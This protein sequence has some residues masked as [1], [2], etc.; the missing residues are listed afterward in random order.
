MG[1]K[2]PTTLKKR[3]KEEDVQPMGEEQPKKRGRP[4][5]GNPE[6]NAGTEGEMTLKLTEAE[7]RF[8]SSRVKGRKTME[9][10]LLKYERMSEVKGKIIEFTTD[11]DRWRVVEDGGESEGGSGYWL[12]E[13]EEDERGEY[14]DESDPEYDIFDDGTPSEMAWQDSGLDEEASRAFWLDTP[15]IPDSEFKSHPFPVF[16]SLGFGISPTPLGATGSPWSTQRGAHMSSLLSVIALYFEPTQV[17][18]HELLQ[19]VWKSFAAMFGTNMTQGHFPNTLNFPSSLPAVSTSLLPMPQ[20][21]LVRSGTDIGQ[22][23]F[24]Y[25]QASPPLPHAVPSALVSTPPRTIVSS[26]LRGFPSSPLAAHSS[27]I[28]TQNQLV[29]S[30]RR[31]WSTLPRMTTPLKYRFVSSA[32]GSPNVWNRSD[33]YTGSSPR[34]VPSSSTFVTFKDSRRLSQR[35]RRPGRGL[36]CLKKIEEGK[37]ADPDGLEG[38]GSDDSD[39]VEGG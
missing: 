28:S 5:K 30:A 3:K 32:R 8:Q 23:P 38:E 19:S 21:Q 11:D 2:S 27:P 29:P 13:R 25:P 35:P 16:S 36:L 6:E 1:T 20:N 33:L 9:S 26:N 17:P 37:A 12:D 39:E 34:R 22:S 4:R 31:Q 24:S 18:Q 15:K 7:D 14:S 10:L